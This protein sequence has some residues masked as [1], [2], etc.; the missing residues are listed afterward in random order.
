MTGAGADIGPCTDTTGGGCGTGAG[1]G[2]G[3]GTATGTGAGAAVAWPLA[4]RAA[5]SWPI[6]VASSSAV[7]GLN[8][9]S[10]DCTSAARDSTVPFTTPE[11]RR[12]GV[13]PRPG[14]ARTYWQT[15]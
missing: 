4:S 3:A 11:I 14:W 6:F 2:G 7:N 13:L 12:K 8:M 5:K 10:V 9:T 15:S 1:D